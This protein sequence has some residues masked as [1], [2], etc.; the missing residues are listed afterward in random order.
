MDSKI[1]KVLYLLYAASGSRKSEVLELTKDSIDFQKRMIIPSGQS[2]VTRNCFVSFYN[3][4]AER[5]LNEID[6]RRQPFQR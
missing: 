4:E 2:G 3:R 6:R 5:A 1:G